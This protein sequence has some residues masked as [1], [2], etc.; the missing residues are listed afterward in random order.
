VTGFALR[1]LSAA[2]Q[3]AGAELFIDNAT[4]AAGRLGVRSLVSLAR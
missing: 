1:A 2:L 4:G 3:V